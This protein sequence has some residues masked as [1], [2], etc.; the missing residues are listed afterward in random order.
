MYLTDLWPLLSSPLTGSEDNSLYVYHKFVSSP[1]LTYK[2]EVLP[3]IQ[4]GIIGVSMWCPTCLILSLKHSNRQRVK[5]GSR[6]SVS[7]RLH[8]CYRMAAWQW[9]LLFAIQGS[10]VVLAASS[11]GLIK[12]SLYVLGCSLLHSYCMTKYVNILWHITWLA[13]LNIHLLYVLQVLEMV[14][15]PRKIWTGRNVESK[16]YIVM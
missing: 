4:V 11:Q 15:E 3:S 8:T 7:E 9:I 12:V 5:S 2:F 1:I 13:C 6:L 14:Q 16:W 10:N